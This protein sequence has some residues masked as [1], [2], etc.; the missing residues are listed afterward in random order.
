[1]TMSCR[2][3]LAIVGKYDL[4]KPEVCNKKGRAMATGKLKHMHRKSFDSEH[5]DMQTR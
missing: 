4:T 5:T 1:M 3:Y 2:I